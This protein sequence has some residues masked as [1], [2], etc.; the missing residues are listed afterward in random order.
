VA[1]RKTEKEGTKNKTTEWRKLWKENVFSFKFIGPS[2]H[3]HLPTNHLQPKLCRGPSSRQGDGHDLVY[4][5]DAKQRA[6]G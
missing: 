6:M 5:G 3:H 1:K 4:N 2:K